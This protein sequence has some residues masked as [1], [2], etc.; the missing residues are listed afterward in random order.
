MFC[1]NI[2]FDRNEI[3]K[4]GDFAGARINSIEF[5]YIKQTNPYMSPEMKK[6]GESIDKNIKITAKTDIW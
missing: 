5:P 1:R 4:L 3:L 6:L 2:L